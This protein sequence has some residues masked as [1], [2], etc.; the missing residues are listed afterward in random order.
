MFGI[1]STELIVILIIVLIVLGP[2]Q[3][4]GLARNLGKA[5]AELK[6]AT[7]DFKE[8]LME[9]TEDVSSEIKDVKKQLKE[10]IPTL[11]DLEKLAE[12]DE[13]KTNNKNDKKK[14]K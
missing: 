4:P 8:N 11:D 5:L 14:Q 10:N 7:R 9:A 1:G 6:G 12:K 3:L 2:K 13:K